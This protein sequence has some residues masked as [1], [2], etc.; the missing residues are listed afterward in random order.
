MAKGK[1][2]I[3]VQE[4]KRERER[5]KCINNESKASKLNNVKRL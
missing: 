3:I 1:G 2:E 4:S 5:V